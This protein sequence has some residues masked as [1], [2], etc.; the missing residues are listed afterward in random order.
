[1]RVGRVHGPIVWTNTTLPAKAPASRRSGV[2]AELGHA[3][4]SRR[5]ATSVATGG[6]HSGVAGVKR[7]RGH[8]PASN[9]GCQ[10]ISAATGAGAP[11]SAAAARR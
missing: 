7:A 4:R 11:A 10:S 6:V 1:M 8:S 3:C 9:T 2:R 5:R